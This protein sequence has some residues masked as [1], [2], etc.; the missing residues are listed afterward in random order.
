MVFKNQGALLFAA[1]PK[2]N[3]AYTLCDKSRDDVPLAV[4]IPSIDEPQ[5][6]EA[7]YA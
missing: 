6:W 5:I 1:S 3:P 2:P 7:R 4:R